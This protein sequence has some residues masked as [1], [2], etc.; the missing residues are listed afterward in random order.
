MFMSGVRDMPLFCIMSSSIY[1]HDHKNGANVRGGMDIQC[2]MIVFY[3]VMQN[4]I[5][6]KLLYVKLLIFYLC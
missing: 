6:Y 5:V 2:C 4:K 1:C 3:G